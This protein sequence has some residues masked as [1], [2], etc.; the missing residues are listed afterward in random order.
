[1]NFIRIVIVKNTTTALFLVILNENL[2]I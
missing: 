2:H 1:M